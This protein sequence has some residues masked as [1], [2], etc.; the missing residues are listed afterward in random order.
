MRRKIRCILLDDDEEQLYL[1]KSKLSGLP[2]VEV[3]CS[4]TDA[5]SFIQWQHTNAGYDLLISDID[6]PGFDGFEVANRIAPKPV[7]F[8]TG[9]PEKG[10]D[11][12]SVANAIGVI[13]KPVKLDIL[14]RMLKQIQHDA[15]TSITLRTERA[16]LEEIKLAEIAYITTAKDERRDKTFYFR[17]GSRLTA[18]LIKFDELLDL[19]GKDTFIP[20]NGSTIINTDYITGLISTHEIGIAVGQGITPIEVVSSYKEALVRLKPNLFRFK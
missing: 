1:L 19:I 5:L 12:S 3:T 7:L 8:V 10:I 13:K 18:K 16:K 17:N 20:I 6:M 15:G 11:Y 9:Y 2:E 14:Q 4:F